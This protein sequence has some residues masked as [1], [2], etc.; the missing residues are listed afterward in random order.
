MSYMSST[1]VPVLMC[2]P[3][4]ILYCDIHREIYYIEL[5]LLEFNYISAYFISF[6]SFHIFEC[7]TYD[8][9]RAANTT[10]AAHTYTLMFE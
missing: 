5:I 7:N 4:G 2:C 1:H 8:Y 9:I 3:T 6:Y 10:P